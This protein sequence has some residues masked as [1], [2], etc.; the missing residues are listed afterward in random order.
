METSWPIDKWQEWTSDQNRDS[1]QPPQFPKPKDRADRG[2]VFALKKI[3][4]NDQD[5]FRSE[6]IALAKASGHVQKEKHLIKLLFAFQSGSYNY[7]MSE[8]ADG[9]L[10]D[11]WEH[12]TAQDVSLRWFSDQVA[13]IC[14]AI[15]R[16]HGLT[17]FQKYHQ[18]ISSDRDQDWGLL[19]QP[20]D[21]GLLSSP[22]RYTDSLSLSLL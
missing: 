21:T 18:T 7:L 16:I 1:P 3:M 6:L 15:K 13:G 4:S 10:A 2:K 19:R 9:N 8:S 14:R 17:T 11:F 5:V 12:K 20:P 22:Y